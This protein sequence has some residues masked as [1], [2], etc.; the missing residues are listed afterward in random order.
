MTVQHH[1]FEQ[2]S[3]EWLA[4]RCGVLT[5]SEIKLIMTPTLKIAN[6]DKSRAHVWEIAAQRISQYVEPHYIGDDMLRGMA[7]EIK[8][9]DLYSKTRAPVTE[10]GFITN[11]EL[12]FTVG[13]SPDGL[14]GDHGLIEVKS[15]NQKFQVQTIAENAVP[16]EYMLQLQ[17]GLLVTGRDWIDFISYS[18]GMPMFTQRVYP[19]P[20][21]QAAIKTAATDFEARVQAAIADY[22][23]NVAVYG[24]PDT[25]REIE[26]EMYVGDAA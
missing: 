15:R 12:G 20:E 22:R 25:E 7:D 13:Y 5:A 23:A 19:D 11:D 2:G 21:M 10:A 6:N 4:A 14:V 3:E 16:D 8:A 17:T 1:D 24:F 26:Q 9:R 18:G